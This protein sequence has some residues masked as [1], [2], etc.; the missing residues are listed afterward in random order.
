[1]FQV[2]HKSE[3]K[4]QFTRTV[5]ALSKYFTKQM[6]YGGHHAPHQRF[7][8]TRADGTGCKQFDGDWPEDRF[9]LG[10]A[11]DGLYPLKECFR[12]KCQ[13]CLHDYMGPVQQDNVHKDEVFEQLC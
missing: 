5:E 8:G 7:K 10:K 9:H 4:N 6:K 2:F 12:K 13:G 1:M 3:N 11:D